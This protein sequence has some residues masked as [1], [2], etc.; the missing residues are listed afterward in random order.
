M[1]AIRARLGV[2][3]LVLE[4]ALSDAHAHISSIQRVALLDTIDRAQLSPEEMAE[5][6]S[7]VL[8]VKWAD[9]DKLHVLS[10]VAASAAR[11]SR[12]T[13]RRTMQDFRSRPPGLDHRARAAEGR[14]AV[15]RYEEG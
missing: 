13:S 9:E 8:Q 10:R 3:R 2:A 5:I 6:A 15:G 7:I 4:G 1:F 11:T 12:P 14:A